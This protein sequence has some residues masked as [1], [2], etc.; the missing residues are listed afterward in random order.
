MSPETTVPDLA[1]LLLELP[2]VRDS[3]QL[4]RAL[5][6]LDDAMRAGDT[7][8]DLAEAAR[9][10]EEIADAATWRATLLKSG[11]VGEG[12]GG[13]PLVLDGELL[14][15]RRYWHYERE[16]AEQLR[17]RAADLDRLPELSAD[18]ALA[19]E[20]AELFPANADALVDGVDW[21]RVAACTALAAGLSVIGGGPGTGKTSVAGA[22]VALLARRRARLGGEPLRSVIAAPTG[23][24][25]QRL[26]ES[27]LA[28]GQRLTERGFLR[29]D[30]LAGL[31]EHVATLHRLLRERGIDELDLLV[32]DELSMA[33]SATLARVLARVGDATQI[34]L[35]G[36]PQQLASVEAGHVLGAIAARAAERVPRALA[37][38]YQRCG[39]ADEPLSGADE[40]DPLAAVQVRL[41]KNWRSADAPA[42]A[43]LN[44]ALQ[45]G[46]AATIPPST[47]AVR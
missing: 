15:S 22:I 26:R 38:W 13:L 32:I 8:L 7:C 33:D 3:A 12:P 40:L 42:L 23:K 35:L 28:D 41:R 34:V 43:A 39:G 47:W 21:Q 25:A 17:R 45:S 24:A 31:G 19:D 2:G 6:L 37:S 10:D 44:A 27:L 36:D 1:R 30:E 46:A 20:I 9:H 5:A 18:D 11:L 14:S 16:L 29:A 4:R